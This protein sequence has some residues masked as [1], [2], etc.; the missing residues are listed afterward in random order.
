MS[1]VL[2]GNECHL[3][4]TVVEFGCGRDS[5][6]VSILDDDYMEVVDDLMSDIDERNDA[7]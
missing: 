2:A 1:I 6:H 4:K 3:D 5:I 7:Y